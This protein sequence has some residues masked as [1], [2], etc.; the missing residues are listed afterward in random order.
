MLLG[1]DKASADL[2]L[3]EN[4][5]MQQ[6]ARQGHSLGGTE[7][8]KSTVIQNQFTNHN[9]FI[10]TAEQPMETSD[11]NSSQCY[12]STKPVHL[13]TQGTILADIDDRDD[14]SSQ[15]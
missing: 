14:I 1:Q 8:Q 5:I 15:R 13:P 12:N 3:N 9:Y 11:K 6:R 7:A 4:T 2:L 10:N